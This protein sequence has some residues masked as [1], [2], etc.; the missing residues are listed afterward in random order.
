MNRLL[1]ADTVL[2]FNEFRVFGIPVE[3]MLITTNT[4]AYPAEDVASSNLIAWYK[5]DEP[6]AFTHPTITVD[7]VVQSPIQI[8]GTN[9]FY[10]AFTSTTAV[11]NITFSSNISCDI[12]IV[13]GG[14]GG[15]D[16]GGGGA[17]LLQTEVVVEEEIMTL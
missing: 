7:G 9:D 3:N 5:F 14:G 12:L 13:G 4:L 2:Q 15:G 1:G 17:G 6:V 16:F 10:Y 11:N 8:S